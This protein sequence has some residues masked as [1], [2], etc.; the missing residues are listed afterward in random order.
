MA[1]TKILLFYNYVHIGRPKEIMNWQKELCIRLS[2][3]GRILIA[4]EGINATVSG[5]PENI[6][7]YKKEFLAHPL[8]INT[9]M[10]ESDGI[11]N[12]FPKLSIKIRKEVV[13]LG[14]DPL[15][16]KPSDAET[17]LTPEEAHELMSNDKDLV[18]LDA[19]NNYESRV[20]TFRNA[21][22]P[23]I[24]SFRDFP[25]YIDENIDIFKDK[26]VLMFCTGGIRCERALTYVQSKGVEDVYQ[27]EG[28]IHR[29]AEK[30]PDGHFRGKNYVFDNRITVK[31][32]D[33][34]LTNCDICYIS[35][36][37]YTN[38]ISS[39]CNKHFI[40]CDSCSEKLFHTCSENCKVLVST[41]QA[42]ARPY[43][44]SSKG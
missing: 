5:T 2:L 37:R 10:K 29:Y 17:H 24:D 28:G 43:R 6:E 40:C 8:F 38:C 13:T 27:I 19:R 33:D 32:N 12:D 15:E 22:T 9:D 26:K 3:K 44:I 31:V 21:I 1:D 18:I 41:G 30:Y 4:Y 20:G 23:D 36:D 7:L 35:C 25:K 42:K 14:I 39:L 34:V 11:G 16:I